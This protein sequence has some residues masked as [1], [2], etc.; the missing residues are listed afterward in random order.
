MFLKSVPRISYLTHQGYLP[1]GL[2]GEFLAR[3]CPGGLCPDTNQNYI[4]TSVFRLKNVRATATLLS[5]S[6]SH[7]SRR[8][9]RKLL[10]TICR[11]CFVSKV[12]TVTFKHNFDVLNKKILAFKHNF[13]FQM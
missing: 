13:Q 2:S 9:S 6:N 5:W 12:G 4:K 1:G 11:Q 10:R 7:Q 3:G 8:I